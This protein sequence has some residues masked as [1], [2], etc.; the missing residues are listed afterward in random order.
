LYAPF[1]LFAT[2]II[3]TGAYPS[4]PLHLLRAPR[5]LV[6]MRLFDHH[7]ID[8]VAT[9]R[10]WSCSTTSNGISTILR[11]SGRFRAF[12]KNVGAKG[13]ESKREKKNNKHRSTF[14]RQLILGQAIKS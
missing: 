13:Y 5:D 2:N 3:L 1:G 8:L 9:R 12:Q 14:H 7:G 6:A 11:G 4:A 10:P